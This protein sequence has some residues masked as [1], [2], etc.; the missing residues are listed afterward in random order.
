[1]PRV[2]R[3]RQQALCYHLYNRG[4]NRQPLFHEEGDW[5]RFV[6]LLGRYKARCGAEVFHWVLMP[7]HYH[8][9]VRVPFAGLRRFVGGVQQSYAQYHHLR[10]GTCGVLWQGRFHSKAVSADQSLTRCGRYIERNPVR[11]RMVGL[12]WE[13]PW[14]SARWYVRGEA[15]GVND[16]DPGYDA[17]AGLSDAQRQAYAALLQDEADDAWMRSRQERATIGDGV[18]CVPNPRPRVCRYTSQ[19]SGAPDA[20]KP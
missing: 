14:S 7:N 2:P 1:M 13:W 11:A 6:E 12:A 4:V 20:L 16:L 8:L 15:D 10:H 5:R 18:R 9:L 19:M 17:A 3:I